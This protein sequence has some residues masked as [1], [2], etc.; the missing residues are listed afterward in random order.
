APKPTTVREAWA[1]WEEGAKAGNV[2]N[3]SGDPYKPASLRSYER[4][5]R[6]RILPAMGSVRLA[7]VRRPDLQEF[8]DGLLAEGLNESTI[9]C[10]LLPLRAIFRRALSR[11]EL[12]VN[13]CSG[14][15]LPAIRGRRDRFASPGEAAALIDALP[16]EDRATWATAMYA[17]L[18]RGEL[19][20]LRDH[21]V[22]LAAGVIRVELG[23][24]RKEGP[25]GLKSNAGRRRVPIPSLLRDFLV[26]H[27]IVSAPEG[28][29]FGRT[30]ESPFRPEGLQ[31][32]ADSAWGAAGF[33]RITFHECRHTF[34]SLMIAAGVNAK[35]LSTYMGHAN[36]S[37]TLD[38]YGH[39]MPGSEDEAAGL[40][41]AYLNAEREQADA[42][43][44]QAGEGLTGAQSGAQ[45]ARKA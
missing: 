34:A 1:A 27:R 18:R 42:H 5:M 45:L 21:D 30:P 13:P 17:G 15:E 44:R 23:W 19:Q 41:D 40:L 31:K 2:R 22:D 38:R 37:I 4:A 36:I 26:E 33:E 32:R 9:Q 6:L 20:A 10:T 3:R 16:V 14:L 25:I 8:A 11:G 29:I 39:L 7:D 35:A 24:D 28:L 12:A 43:A